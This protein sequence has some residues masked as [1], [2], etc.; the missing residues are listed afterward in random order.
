MKDDILLGLYDYCGKKYNKTE[1]TDYLNK[2]GEKIPY[3]FEGIDG[4]ILFVTLW[5][6]LY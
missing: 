6:G 1:M 4:I 5:T 3:H 2:L